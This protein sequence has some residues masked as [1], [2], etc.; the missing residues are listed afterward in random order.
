MKFAGK[1]MRYGIDGMLRPVPMY[2]VVE[3]PKL[4]GRKRA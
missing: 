1:S 4:R 2:V 3:T